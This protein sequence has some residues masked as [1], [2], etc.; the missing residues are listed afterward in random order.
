MQR[1]GRGGGKVPRYG[2]D[3]W[4]AGW[5]LVS[6]YGKIVGKLEAEMEMEAAT[7]GGLA[8]SAKTKAKN[9]LYN[10]KELERHWKS[11]RRKGI[12]FMYEN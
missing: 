3:G 12:T 4:E 11:D 1:E 2:A 7:G 5:W 6:R 9:R 8:K 10:R